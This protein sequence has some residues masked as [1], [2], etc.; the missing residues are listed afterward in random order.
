MKGWLVLDIEITIYRMLLEG[1][2]SWLESGMRKMTI[3]MKT[4]RGYSDG[5]SSQAL[6]SAMAWTP[7]SPTLALV[8]A[9]A[10]S[11]T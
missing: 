6:A 4:T 7:S 5:L 8:G 10:P 9:S 1:K 11:A 2:E 3:Y